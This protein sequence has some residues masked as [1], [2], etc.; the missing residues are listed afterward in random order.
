MYDLS[1]MCETE[2]HLAV[3]LQCRVKVGGTRYANESETTRTSDISGSFIP[4]SVIHLRCKERSHSGKSSAVPA[5]LNAG[6]A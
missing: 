1:N 5:F 4:C 6:D 2:S 3:N